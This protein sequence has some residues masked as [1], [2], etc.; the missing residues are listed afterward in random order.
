[1]GPKIRSKYFQFFY[2]F[3]FPLIF[4]SSSFMFQCICNFLRVL[5]S[6]VKEKGK[7]KQER[8]KKPN[9]LGWFVGKVHWEKKLP[10]IFLAGAKKEKLI[11]SI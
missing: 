2:T 9:T 11:L 10:E 4:L 3:F 7:K 5:K 1:M 6:R 8:E